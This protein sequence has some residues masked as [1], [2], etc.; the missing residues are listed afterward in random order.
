MDI[1]IYGVN[2]K[3]PTSRILAEL[4]LTCRRSA[5]SCQERVGIGDV[6]MYMVVFSILLLVRSLGYHQTCTTDSY[7][8]TSDGSFG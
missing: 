6:Q 2:M 5:N 8:C 3:P 1:L 4:L 7:G